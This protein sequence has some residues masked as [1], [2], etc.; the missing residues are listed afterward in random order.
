MSNVCIDAIT[1]AAADM[2]YECQVVH[3]ACAASDLEFNGVNV[4]AIQVHAAFMA[5]LSMMYADV[6]NTEDV[7]KS[8]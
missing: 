7:L 5:A 3:D 6:S 2:E 4:P 8:L 1:R